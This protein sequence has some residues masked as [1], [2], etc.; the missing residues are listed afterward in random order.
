ML[1]FQFFDHL[2][3]VV[4]EDTA[5]ETGVAQAQER[6]RRTLDEC[7]YSRADILRDMR[8]IARLPRDLAP[9]DGI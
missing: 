5:R 6:A 8:L 9:A 7:G 2:G 4:R 1:R 3:L